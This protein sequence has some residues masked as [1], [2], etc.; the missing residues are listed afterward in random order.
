MQNEAKWMIFDSLDMWGLT[1]Y[2]A[3]RKFRPQ[4]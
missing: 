2:P 3:L 4:N 1:I